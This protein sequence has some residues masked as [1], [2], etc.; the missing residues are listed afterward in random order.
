MKKISKIL[1][2][3][4]IF[5]VVT[6]PFI[7]NIEVFVNLGT[8][9]AYYLTIISNS[10]A[11]IYYKVDDKIFQKKLVT[12]KLPKEPIKIWYNQKNP[13]Q[14]VI[15][16]IIN[17]YINYYMTIPFFLLIVYIAIKP[18]LDDKKNF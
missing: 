7:K 15:A 3:S 4:T 2:F 5:Y 18:H 17:L 14:S 9:H 1:F 16:S 6:Y 12:E 11:I 8:T 13:S 10:E